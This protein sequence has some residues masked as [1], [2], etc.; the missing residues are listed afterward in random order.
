MRYLQIGRNNPVS[1]FKGCC[2]IDLQKGLITID[3]RDRT[4]LIRLNS[5]EYEVIQ[6]K[7]E[8]MN[9]R[10]A[11]YVR[12][13]AVQGQ[14][15]TYNLADFRETTRPFRSIG[16]EL[17]QIAKKANETGQVTAEM[18]E[19]IREQYAK[20]ERIFEKYLKPLKPTVLM[21]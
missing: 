10:V 9:I 7:A 5:D 1:H 17:N 21:E 12:Q 8:K 4:L 14:L 15:V 18:V 6:K 3:K 20:L 2:P 11:V 16:N 13:M 19:E